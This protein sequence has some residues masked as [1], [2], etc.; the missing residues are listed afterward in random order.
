LRR[1]SG[2]T[3]WLLR[4]SRNERRDSR[5]FSANERRKRQSR[6]GY[7]AWQRRRGSRR[8]RSRPNM[9]GGYRRCTA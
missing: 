8:R 1:R 9:P 6:P 5:N 4:D 3:K 7:R 2:R